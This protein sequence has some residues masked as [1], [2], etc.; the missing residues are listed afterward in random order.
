MKKSLK[1][2][3]NS[4]F[5]EE[6]SKYK[7]TT[8]QKNGRSNSQTPRSVREVRTAQSPVTTSNTTPRTQF[9][10]RS[11]NSQSRS[12]SPRANPS[13]AKS[14]DWTQ[15]AR[16]AEKWKEFGTLM[17]DSYEDVKRKYNLSI[18]AIEENNTNIRYLNNQIE[19]IKHTILQDTHEKDQQEYLLRTEIESLKAAIQQS[20]QNKRN[21]EYTHMAHEIA[22]LRSEIDQMNAYAARLS[23]DERV[24][25]ST[26]YMQTASPRN[27]S[28]RSTQDTTGFMTRTV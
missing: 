24:N 3:H 14:T 16:D 22:R 23:R 8:S 9:S 19:Q 7:Q 6:L 27:G 20:V 17:A 18:K 1:F 13:L 15:I 12:I 5:R 25:I 26:K 2:I 10:H 11:N 4:R 28:P 21:S